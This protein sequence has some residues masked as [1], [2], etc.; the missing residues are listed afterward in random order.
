MKKIW[1]LSFI[2]F[3]L[4]LLPNLV[5]SGTKF[6]PTRREKPACSYNPYDAGKIG[7]VTIEESKENNSVISA[8]SATL[9]RDGFHSQVE[10]Q[11]IIAVLR[12]QAFALSGFVDPSKAAEVGK[13]IGADSVFVVKFDDFISDYNDGSEVAKVSVDIDKRYVIGCYDAETGE[14]LKYKEVSVKL[15]VPYDFEEITAS[16]F[17]SGSLVNTTTGKVLCSSSGSAKKGVIGVKVTGTPSVPSKVIYEGYKRT[18][19]IYIS[20]EGRAVMA[21]KAV[22]SLKNWPK[23]Y[24]ETTSEIGEY[25]KLP[26]VEMLKPSL[27]PEAS[28]EMAVQIIPPVVRRER[29]IGDGKSETNKLA[30]LKAKGGAWDEAEKLWLLA[31]TDEATDHDAWGGLGIYYEY[32]EMKTKARECYSKARQLDPKNKGFPTWL[33]EIEYMLNDYSSEY[34]KP[35]TALSKFEELPYIA[36]IE[37]KDEVRINPQG[38][39]GREGDIVEIFGLNIKID[40]KTGEVLE[41]EKEAK[42]VAILIKVT[43]KFWTAFALKQRQKIKA[44]DK[45]NIIKEG[46]KNYLSVITYRPAQ[47]EIIFSKPPESNLKVGGKLNVVKFNYK[48]DFDKNTKEYVVEMEEK[49]IGEAEITE[50]TDKQIKAKFLV[51]PKE[52]PK[53]EK[54]EFWGKIAAV[55]L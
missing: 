34:K 18:A 7:I 22:N 35:E 51:E 25:G 54:G 33:K 21:K 26:S 32:K 50:I 6:T 36:Q 4:I 9:S 46:S 23:S 20:D 16:A 2:L 1:F 28:S 5:Y 45:V 39:V 49:T 44:E 17:T 19:N 27:I 8:V 30:I 43:D 37:K 11:R 31:V 40:R 10:R 38:K 15:E 47:K 55:G 29:E 48:I 12:E 24:I 13:L 3:L 42:A 52:G 41:T 14:E 53:P